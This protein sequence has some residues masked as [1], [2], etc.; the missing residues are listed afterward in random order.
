MFE[1]VTT[2][3]GCSFGNYPHSAHEWREGF[4][5]WGKRKSCPGIERPKRIEYKKQLIELPFEPE[6]RIFPCSEEGCE[7][8]KGADDLPHKHY[9]KFHGYAWTTPPGYRQYTIPQRMKDLM[10]QCCDPFCLYEI[11]M[12]REVF[13]NALLKTR[14][15]INQTWPS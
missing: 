12:T 14:K 3:S 1:V 10:F 4:L 6:D 2:P 11:R 9:L 5:W 8:C 15:E 7:E 13:E